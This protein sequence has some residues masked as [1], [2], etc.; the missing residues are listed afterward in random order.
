VVDPTYVA[1]IVCV[2]VV[3]KEVCRVAIPEFSAEVPSKTAGVV[4]V[5]SKLTFPVAPE[6]VTV[7][8][9]VMLAPVE[10]ELLDEVSEMSVDCSVG[11]ATL[12]TTALDVLAASLV[13]PP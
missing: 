13:S 7:A 9:N 5:S 4:V 6:G 11:K 3:V 8:V 1:V 10:G 12:T 2:P